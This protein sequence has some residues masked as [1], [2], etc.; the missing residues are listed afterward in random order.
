MVFEIC[1]WF[2]DLNI[3]R[4]INKRSVRE[5]VMHVE[6]PISRSLRV[7]LNTSTESISNYVLVE[8]Y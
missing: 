8:G 3:T 1:K 4:V 6:C 5:F 7:I 2:N